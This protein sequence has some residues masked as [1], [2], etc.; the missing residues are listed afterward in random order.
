MTLADCCEEIA[1]RV[2]DPSE[3]GHER[4]VGLEHLEAGTTSIRSWGSTQDVTSSMKLFQSGDVIVARRNVYLRRA[5]RADF[6]GL[7]SGDGIVLRPS[8]DVCAPDL[9]PYLL[10]TNRFWDYVTSQAD[11]TMSKRITVERLLA[12][13]FG[14]PPR[15]D[16][17]RI[18][19]VLQSAENCQQQLAA[20]GLRL[21]TVKSAIEVELIHDALGL[22]RGALDLKAARPTD[23]WVVCSGQDLLNDGYLHA[24]QDGNHGSQY[25]RASEMGDEGLPYISASDISEDGEIDLAACRRIR[26]ERAARLRIPPARSGDVI[27]TNNATV[28]RVTRLPTWPTDI[29]AST[30]TTYYRCNPS[31]LDP[32]YLR[33]FFESAVFQFQLSTIMRQSTRNQVPITTQKRLL[34]AVPPS[35]IQRSLA[36]Q[37]TRLLDAKRALQAYSD[38]YARLRSSLLESLLV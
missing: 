10:G 3:S 21:R 30:S 1:Q 5:A 28:G 32:D 33:W 36:A 18:A 22:E 16:Q 11:G 31:R 26:P 29:V 13:E 35:E 34:F 14:L 7:C 6:D 19:D 2:E 15:A 27:L 25:P 37:R 8:E 4:F 12:Y 23:G 38:G 17:E 9:L 24:L 20:A